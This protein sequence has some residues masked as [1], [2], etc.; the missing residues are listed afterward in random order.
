MSRLKHPV[1]TFGFLLGFLSLTGS[2]GAANKT[3]RPLGHNIPA[4]VGFSS[5]IYEVSADQSQ[6]VITLIRTGEFR[7]PVTVGFATADGT[8]RAGREYTAVSGDLLIPAGVGLAT[9]NVPLHASELTEG[10]A[11]VLLKLV[12]Q[13]PATLIVLGDAT[14]VLQ[15]ATGSATVPPLTI[16]TEEPGSVVISW[17]A[18]GAPCAL[19]RSATPRGGVWRTVEAAPELTEG[20][21]K[22][23]EPASAGQFFYRLRAL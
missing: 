6:A 19:E 22:L 12:E 13:D 21:Y 4:Y 16:Q 9:F 15:P 5:S 7:E 18:D 23:R 17:E 10:S 1:R 14:L 11:T 8:A 3:V 20:V 2:I